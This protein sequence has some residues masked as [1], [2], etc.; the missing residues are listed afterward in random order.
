[1]PLSSNQRADL[2]DRQ[3]FLAASSWDAIV[4]A[5]ED[6]TG[7]STSDLYPFLQES[8]DFTLGILQRVLEEPTEYL[9]KPVRKLADAEVSASGSATLVTAPNNVRTFIGGVIV[10]NLS[11]TAADVILYHVRSGETRGNRHAIDRRTVA[12]GSVSLALDTPLEPGD[13]LQVTSAS[14]AVTVAVYGTP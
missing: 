1:M 6:Q 13:T 7:L 4:S 11:G 8:A 10:T 2:V 5:A 14:A 3:P 9:E 12:P